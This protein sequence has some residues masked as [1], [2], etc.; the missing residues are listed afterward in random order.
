MRCGRR[1]RRAADHRHLQRQRDE[2]MQARVNETGL[3]PAD[4]LDHER[5]QRPAD[6]AGKAAEQ[7][8]VGDRTA[9]R[10]AIHPPERGEHRVI[11]PGAHADAEQHPGHQIDRQRRR[12]ADADQAGRVEQRTRQQ[13]RPPAAHVD[14][15]ADLRRDQPGHQQADRRAAD[16]ITQRPAGIGN[17]RPGE[18]G[19]KIKRGAPGQDLRNAQRGDDDAAV[20]RLSLQRQ[21]VIS[22]GRRLHAFGFQHRGGRRPRKRLDQRFGGS[23]VLRRRAQARRIGRGVLDLFGSGPTSVTPFTGTISLIW[24]MPSSASP[25]TM[26]SATW[27]P[28]LS[29]ALGRI[30]S[31]MPSFTSSPSM[32]RLS[33]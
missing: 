22:L 25:L 28:F 20:E 6:R 30:W 15:F 31:A 13:D 3:A 26:K 16:H 29:L 2:E 23:L 19:R 1:F 4:M 21:N 24:W 10:A 12:Q 32:T 7:R 9:R 8:Q 17:D 33:S 18:H 11:E 5:A 27:P 14:D